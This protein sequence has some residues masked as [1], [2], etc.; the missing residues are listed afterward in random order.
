M[1]KKTLRALLVGINDYHPDSHNVSNLDGSVND[2]LRIDDF[3]KAQYEDHAEIEL[4]SHILINDE[5]TREGVLNA[6][7]KNLVESAKKGDIVYFHYSGHGSQEPA[8]DEFEKWFKDKKNETL[9]CYDSRVPGGMDL[10]DKE[11]GALLSQIPKGVHIVLTADSC[12]SGSISRSVG[13][14]GNIKTRQSPGTDVERSLDTYLDGFY[15]KM[16][17]DTGE[18]KL[19][20]SDHLSLSAC[21]RSEK[22]KEI[23]GQGLF[24]K[25]LLS[26]LGETG[27]DRSYAGLYSR[28][29]SVVTN[30][31]MDQ[32]PQFE[33]YGEVSP[34][35]TFLEGTPAA[36]APTPVVKQDKATGEWSMNY[37]AI[38]GITHEM[39]D[40]IILTVFKN[41]DPE[42]VVGKARVEYLGLQTSNLMFVGAEPTPPA[43]NEPKLRATV[44]AFPMPVFIKNT[45]GDTLFEETIKKIPDLS[46]IPAATPEETNYEI[47][48]ENG[49]IALYKRDPETLLIGFRDMGPKQAEFMLLTL[50]QV[51]NW[52]Q[53]INL[54]NPETNILPFEVELNVYQ[55]DSTEARPGELWV[56]DYVK[57]GERWVKV[58]FAVKARNEFTK[59]LYFNL[60]YFSPQFGIRLINDDAG[61]LATPPGEERPLYADDISIT[62]ADLNEDVDELLLVAST[63][64]LTEFFFQQK[65]IN[66]RIFGRNVPWHD[67]FMPTHRAIGVEEPRVDWTTR[68]FTIKVVRKVAEVS[69]QDIALG[70]GM[71]SIAGHDQF[72]A[73]LSLQGLPQST[74]SVGGEVPIHKMVDR[75]PDTELVHLGQASNGPA[76]ALE[77]SGFDE[78]AQARLKENPL[79]L[80]L[81]QSLGE[82][83]AILP[84]TFDGEFFLPVGKPT[85][86]DGAAQFE[87]DYLPEEKQNTRS[88]GKA[89]KLYFLKTAVSKKVNRLCRVEYL[90]NGNAIEQTEEWVK[91]AIA[92]ADKILLVIHGIIGNTEEMA[93]SVYFAQKEDGP[94]DLVLSYDYENLA[95]QISET[96]QTL[97][98]TLLDLGIEGKTLDIMAHSMGGL[99]S[100]W[101]IEK[102]GG[103]QLVR[104]L[105]MLGTPNN[106]SFF[107][108]WHRLF[109]P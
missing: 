92:Q 84:F 48:L 96:A 22:A 10:A 29:N 30:F 27:G 21:R 3:L 35:T 76:V 44:P 66:P 74:R 86:K 79:K 68:R 109:Q 19:P 107:P 41:N 72:R 85:E 56:V 93:K 45:D 52:E 82:G 36:M 90:E 102:E 38:H 7:R 39:V 55:G 17:A 106:G 15:T 81:N 6:F 65:G 12:H 11:I 8:P 69:D 2:V 103:D 80:D 100:R 83:E 71:V 70:D 51:A 43:A 37:G 64:P 57:D 108:N 73:G 62:K 1:S 16:L 88:L 105:I 104:R 23:D 50:R 91:E 13:D 25:T 59:K 101:M 58:P 42:Q 34:L 98:S 97:K 33:F 77:I 94:Y 26:S 67:S 53:L 24:T 9:V 54:E 95:T 99:V 4:D 32:H 40:N 47:R 61:Q 49:G 31:A 78:G 89:L 60:L 5:A 18:I 63:E 14:V 20:E 28:I 75:I 46:I 87:I